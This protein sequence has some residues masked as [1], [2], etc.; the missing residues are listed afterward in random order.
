MHF[1]NN[2]IY[3]FYL[4]SNRKKINNDYN[5]RNYRL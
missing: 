5:D 4:I 1:S 3:I 2:F